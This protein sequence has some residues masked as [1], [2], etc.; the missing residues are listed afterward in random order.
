MPPK[1]KY[2][3]QEIIEKA[4]EIIGEEGFEKLTARE[5]AASLGTS[6]K[7]IFTAFENMEDLKQSCFDYAYQKY[8]SYFEGDLGDRPF[9]TIG[10]TYIEFA[11]KEPKL[12]QIIFLR[13]Q[14]ESIPFVQYMEKLDDNFQNTINLVKTTAGLSEESALALYKHMWITCTGVAALLAT[15]Q[16]NFTDEEID[17][18]LDTTYCGIV[19]RLK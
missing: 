11:R 7:P 12:Y 3:K 17:R 8:H 19:E 10:R 4:V 14:E 9:R 1:A 6:V 15:K 13:S 2:S 5:L 16:C 18:V